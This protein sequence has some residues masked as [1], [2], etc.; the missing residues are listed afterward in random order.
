MYFVLLHFYQIN[1]K[2]KYIE[3]KC[4]YHTRVKTQPPWQRGRYNNKI[5]WIEAI[6]ELGV[7]L[8]AST[9]M[10]GRGGDMGGGSLPS[11]DV[12][13]EFGTPMSPPFPSRVGGMRMRPIGRRQHPNLAV[14]CGLEGKY[15]CIE[16][17]PMKNNSIQHYSSKMY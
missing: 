7:S 8:V 5:G 2:K 16:R 17:I 10:R 13:W 15:K 9:P 1:S 11:K 4:I 6:N 14:G 3:N 12:T